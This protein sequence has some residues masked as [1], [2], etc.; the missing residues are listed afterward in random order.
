M[1]DPIT[2]S[3]RRQMLAT[4]A[5]YEI[6]FISQALREHIA[7]NDS[8]G[9]VE[10]L[11]RGMLARVQQLSE[12]ADECLGNGDDWNEQKLGEIVLCRRDG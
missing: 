11:A 12:A 9:L 8:C 10:P 7:K 5:L 4:T 3:A 1:S 2:I 6:T